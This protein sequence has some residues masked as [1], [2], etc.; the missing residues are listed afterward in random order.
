M[1]CCRIK[2]CGRELELAGKLRLLY[3]AFVVNSIILHYTI[4]C[5]RCG[6]LLVVLVGGPGDLTWNCGKWFEGLGLG[7][8]LTRVDN[9]IMLCGYYQLRTTSR[10]SGSRYLFRWLII[11]RSN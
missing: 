6:L 8:T 9:G 3:I 1:R 2:D 5:L 10:R 7:I 11:S 4:L